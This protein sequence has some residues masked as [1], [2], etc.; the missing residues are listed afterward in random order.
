MNGDWLM[1]LRLT[2]PSDI[3][4]NSFLHQIIESSETHEFATLERLE[5]STYQWL[6]ASLLIRML[7][8]RC[9]SEYIEPIRVLRLRGDMAM[10]PLSNMSELIMHREHRRWGAEFELL[11]ICGV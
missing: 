8:A 1:D 11:D 3:L 2:G 6:D 7:S 10:L 4:S 5:L 9:N